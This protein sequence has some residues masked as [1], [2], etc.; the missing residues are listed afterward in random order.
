MIFG[1]CLFFCFALYYCILCYLSSPFLVVFSAFWALPTIENTKEMELQGFRILVV[2]DSEDKICCLMLEDNF[3]FHTQDNIVKEVQFRLRNMIGF[4]FIFLFCLLLWVQIFRCFAYSVS[5]S[6]FP[7][8]ICQEYSLRH[9][10]IHHIA[11]P[12]CFGQGREG[13]DW[14]LKRIEW[15]LTHCW[16]NSWQG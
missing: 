12:T 2:G 10:A 1:C 14:Q 15:Y 13:K 3:W 11:K 5:L 9:L 16:A 6:R 8:C 4:D 7:D